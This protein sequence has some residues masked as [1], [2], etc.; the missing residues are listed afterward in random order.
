MKVRMAGYSG[1][2]ER[3]W[4]GGR[5]VSGLFTEFG[6]RVWRMGSQHYLKAGQGKYP[7]SAAQA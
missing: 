7:Y 4:R 3:R 6:H 2:V 5:E 1:G